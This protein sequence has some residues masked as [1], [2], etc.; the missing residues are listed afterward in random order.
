[1]AYTDQQ[2]ND[3]YFGTGGSETNIRPGVYVTMSGFDVT[4]LLFT[5]CSPGGSRYDA[6]FAG[7]YA[8]ALATGYRGF[9]EYPPFKAIAGSNSFAGGGQIFNGP[10]KS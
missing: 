6:D 2:M 9:S 3:W 1:V 4:A 10:T 5:W 7:K 8:Q